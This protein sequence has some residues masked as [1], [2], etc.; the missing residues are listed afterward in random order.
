MEAYKPFINA[1]FKAF[2]DISEENLKT[3][4]SSKPPSTRNNY[5]F[6]LCWY[7][8]QQKLPTKKKNKLLKLIRSYTVI[9]M[10]R[11]EAMTDE[12]LQK[13]VAYL[14]D[15]Q[16]YQ[17][18]Y[19]LLT[20]ILAINQTGIRIGEL[21]NMEY[22][23]NLDN[24][25]VVVRILGKRNIMRYVYIT[26]DIWNRIQQIKT[27]IKMMKNLMSKVTKTVL[28]YTKGLHS[29]RHRFATKF[30]EVNK[31][32]YKL[33]HYLGH[34]NIQTT[35]LYYLHQQTTVDDI[36]PFL[37]TSIQFPHQPSNRWL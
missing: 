21:Y 28:G 14:E 29:I 16:Q 10:V 9:R 31:D 7:V 26:Q 17:C 6:A 37:T 27:K 25:I 8:K 18:Y 13:I 12:E 5:V 32:I 15:K 34:R 22:V 4:L 36:V 3:F 1:Y 35:L 30:M 23:K 20:A 24:N 2:S 33:S 19:D 11:R